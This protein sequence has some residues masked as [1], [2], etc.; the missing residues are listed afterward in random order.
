MGNNIWNLGDLAPGAERN[1]SILGKM[2]DVFDGE[3]KVFRAWSGS[4]SSSDKSLI[5]VVFN[6]LE[7]IMFI[8]NLQLKQGFLLMAFI[9]ENMP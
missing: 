1:I 9:K 7:H 4:Q 3:Q 6:S 2:I 5:D 8:K